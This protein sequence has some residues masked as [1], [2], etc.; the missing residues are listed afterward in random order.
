MTIIRFG[1]LPEFPRLPR[2][3]SFDLRG[4]PRSRD[5][6]RS[7]LAGLRLRA[8]VQFALSISRD[9]TAAADS[10]RQPVLLK[11]NGRQ[12]FSHRPCIFYL[13]SARIDRAPDFVSLP[14]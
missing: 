10:N 13:R 11:R 1:R 3:D 5:G 12:P 4:T 14:D 2:M 7:P 6:G 8:M 9:A